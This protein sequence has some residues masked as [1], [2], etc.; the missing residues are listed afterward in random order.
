[1]LDAGGP[2]CLLIM[3]VVRSGIFPYVADTLMQNLYN[4]FD[5]YSC[6]T[7]TKL[8]YE[9]TPTEWLSVTNS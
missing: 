4:F 8:A 1:V 2:Q 7:G 9:I 5:F 3:S 6:S